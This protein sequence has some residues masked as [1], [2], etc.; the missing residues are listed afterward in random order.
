MKNYLLLLIAVLVSA[1]SCVQQEIDVPESLDVE[2]P[3]DELM[4]S[5][6][7]PGGTKVYLSEDN[8]VLWSKDD[9]I[10]LFNGNTEGVIYS[11]HDNYVG[12]TTGKFVFDSFMNNGYKVSQIDHRVAYY[13]LDYSLTCVKGN[14][15]GQAYHLKNISLPSVQTYVQGN[16][17]QSAFPMAVVADKTATELPFR[18]VSGILKLQFYGDCVVSGIS[19]TGNNDEKLSGSAEVILEGD[20]RTPRIQMSASSN[21]SVFLDCSNEV[22]RLNRRTPTVFMIAIPPTEFTRGFKITV[23]DTDGKDYVI[24]TNNSQSVGRST[25]L[26]MSPISVDGEPVLPEVD[27]M[28]TIVETDYDGYSMLVTVPRSVKDCGN[29]IRWNQCCLMMYN[30]VSRNDNDFT[31]LLYNASKWT[32]DDLLLEYTADENWYQTDYD[33]D[34]D[35]V[36]DWDYKFN[37]IVPGEPV[38]FYAGEFAYVDESYSGDY[39]SISS[40]LDNWG[41]GYYLPALEENWYNPSLDDNPI[42]LDGMSLTRP[43]DNAWTGA[44]QRKF[45]KVREPSVLNGGVDVSL[46]E[47]TPTNLKFEIYPDDNVEQYV[48]L[49]LDDPT[50]DWFMGLISNREDFKQWAV[51]SYFSFYNLLTFYHSGA[52]IIDAKSFFV[53][54]CQADSDYHVL[55]TSMGNSEGTSQS[56]Q[57]FTF[58]TASKIMPAPVI[59]VTPVGAT[60]YDV[61]FNVKCTSAKDGNPVVKAYYA[62]NYVREWVYETNR[63]GSY[64][65]L[66]ENNVQFSEYDLTEINSDAGLTVSFPSLDGE[67]TRF[68]VLGY[69][70]ENT[71]NDFAYPNDQILNCPAVA[72]QTAEWLEKKT[73]VDNSIFEKLIG[74]WTATATLIHDGVR[75]TSSSTITISDNACDHPSTLPSDIYSLYQTFGYSRSEVDD[76]WEEFKTFADIFT[77]K[78]LTNQNR[79]LCTGWIEDN[80]VE[81]LIAR[82]P[83]E[84][85]TAHDYSGYDVETMFY[86]FG[87]KWYIEAVEDK[88]TG[89][90]SLIAPFSF[91]QLPPASNWSGSFHFGAYDYESN[92][93]LTECDEVFNGF[94]VEYD[95]ENDMI[96]INPLTCYGRYYYPDLIYSDQYGNMTIRNFVASDIVL[97]RGATESANSNKAVRKSSAVYQSSAVT[98]VNARSHYKPRTRLSAPA[99]ISHVEIEIPTLEQAK[100]NA[101]KYVKKILN[102]E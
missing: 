14:N 1:V 81:Y 43:M 44:F 84:L 82:T 46:V 8:R 65:D 57:E 69:N 100:A 19:L 51:T 92:L 4:F 77:E 2:N 91:T 55:V 73:P 40:A 98:S 53:D 48:M 10:V 45:F 35:G 60:P 97:T 34:C 31:S 101:D 29:V 93:L 74:E 63:G 85:F 47:A 25:I 99:V 24:E 64:V 80:A 95:E 38:V 23:T 15:D 61:S 88:S 12:K 7:E 16:V 3:G 39:Y 79:L 78:R 94:R 6:E 17:D 86:D 70:S 75:Y 33:D 22:V 52:A 54:G 67:T 66:I 90:V 62:V 37:P 68:A 71:H 27:E 83:Y 28:L 58:R 56:F 30:Y 20:Y 26:R 72:D 32:T 102:C 87:P 41:P 76:M 18:N 9:R 50:Y 13:P 49:I 42:Y 96:F 11:L 36:P 5:I 89:R 21:S 59:E